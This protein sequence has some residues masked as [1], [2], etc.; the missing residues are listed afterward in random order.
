[1]KTEERLRPFDQ[2]DSMKSEKERACETLKPLDCIGLGYE[3]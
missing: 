1:M 2:L 3:I